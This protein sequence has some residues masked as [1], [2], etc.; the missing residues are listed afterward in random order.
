MASLQELELDE[1]S[2]W[3]LLPQLVVIL[4]IMLLI[5]GAGYWFYLMP[6]QDEIE[7]LKQEEET[8]KATLRIKA[9]KVAVLPQIQAQ[10]DELK[11]RYDFLLR[12]LPV[13]KELASMLASVNQLGLDSSLT[14]TRIDWGERESQEFLYRL[15]LNIELTGSY[16]DIGDF[17]QAIAKLPRIINFDDVDWQRVSQESSTLHFRVRAYTYQFKQEVD[18]EK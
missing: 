14:F 3:P 13:Q 8:V 6:K 10:L 9:N 15:P 2:E 5:Q 17:S 16:H 4:L 7:L 1:I 11:E 12:Q 18:D